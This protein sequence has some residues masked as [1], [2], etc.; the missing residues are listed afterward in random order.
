MKPE[1][2]VAVAS[3]VAALIQDADADEKFAGLCELGQVAVR[4]PVAFT[5]EFAVLNALLRLGATNPPDYAKM[6]DLVDARRVAAGREPLR[7][8]ASQGYNVNEYMRDFMAQK[9]DRQRRAV[10]IENMIRAGRDALVGRSRVEF[11]DRQAK[12]W[13]QERDAF[14]ERVRAAHGGRAPRDVQTRDLDQVWGAVDKQLDELEY[15]ARQEMR[16]PLGA[17]GAPTSLATL[18]NTLKD[19]PYKK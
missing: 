12:L 19:D 18:L 4:Y 8:P 1:D 7:R 9:R 11:M 14:L 10:E 17:K 6:L 13:K 15:L 5:G 16:N 2:K 3:A